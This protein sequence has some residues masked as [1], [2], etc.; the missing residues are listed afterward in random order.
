MWHFYRKTNWKDEEDV[1]RKK[2]VILS[3][4]QET[5]QKQLEALDR[6]AHEIKKHI[7]QMNTFNALFAFLQIQI[8]LKAEKH[9]A[10][11]QQIQ[12]LCKKYSDLTAAALTAE[13]ILAAILFS[14]KKV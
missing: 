8:V 13:V 5:R 14:L 3:L 4:I 10:I 2:V 9:H 11:V 12:N 7:I 6:L 1:K